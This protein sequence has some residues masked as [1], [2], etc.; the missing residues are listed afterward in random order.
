[1]ALAALAAILEWLKVPV[2]LIGAGYLFSS[3]SNLLGSATGRNPV[4]EISATMMQTVLPLLVTL[5]PVVMMTNM[6]MGMMTQIMAPVQRIGYAGY[7][8]GVVI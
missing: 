2:M 3:L 4:A 6:M 8:S 5:M 7:P 1:M